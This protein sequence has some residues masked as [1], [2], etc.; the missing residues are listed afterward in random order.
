VWQKSPLLL[1]NPYLT[2]RDESDTIYRDDDFWVTSHGVAKTHVQHVATAV[3]IN[4]DRS[5]AWLEGWPQ[6]KRCL[7]RFAA[8]PRFTVGMMKAT[9]R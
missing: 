3:A 6:V 1:G 8:L 9:H 4:V 2:L 5:V 7:S